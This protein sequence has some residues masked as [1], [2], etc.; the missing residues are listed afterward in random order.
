[1]G[2]KQAGAG[3]QVAG[4]VLSSA[5]SLIPDERRFSQANVATKNLLGPNKRTINT[6]EWWEAGKTEK[7]LT[8]VG[9]GISAAGAFISGNAEGVTG[10]LNKGIK[11]VGGSEGTAAGNKLFSNMTEDMK[12]SSGIINA[13]DMDP[14]TGLISI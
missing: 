9:A 6:N 7:I 1:M 11:A 10:I 13:Q 3:M 14:K 8:G 4:A 12:G 5:A 2:V